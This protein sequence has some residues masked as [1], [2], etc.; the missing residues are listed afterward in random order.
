MFSEKVFLC[1]LVSA[2]AI[3]S[4]SCK[5]L[6]QRISDTGRHFVCCRTSAFLVCWLNYLALAPH[7]DFIQLGRHAFGHGQCLC[8]VQK[9]RHDVHRIMTNFSCHGY[10]NSPNVAIEVFYASLLPSHCEM[11]MRR[12]CSN[13]LLPEESTALPR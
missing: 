2:L 5:R 12:I 7:V 4:K 6:Q 9:H 1:N 3:S 8:A 13:S 11:A 10:A